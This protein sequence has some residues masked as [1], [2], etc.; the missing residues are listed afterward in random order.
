MNRIS[1]KADGNKS[2]QQEG[3]GFPLSDK[4][5]CCEKNRKKYNAFRTYENCK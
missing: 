5:K 2:R 3:Y 4:D 1:R